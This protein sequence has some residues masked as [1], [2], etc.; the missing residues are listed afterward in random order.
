M[1]SDPAQFVSGEEFLQIL[2]RVL[3]LTEQDA[4]GQAKREQQALEAERQRTAEE[5][6][7]QLALRQVEDT[8]AAASAGGVTI[9]LSNITFQANSALLEEVERR[10]IRE[11]AEILTTMPGRKILVEGHTALAGTEA[12]Q[13]QTSTERAQA[14]ADY[15]VELGARRR[16]EITVRGY[17]ASRPV[18]DN[19]NAAGQAQNRRVEITILE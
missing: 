18:A 3:R 9:S 16:N 10:K 13:L 17:G 7:T 14:V 11:I 8:H 15:L 12:A 2:S 6:N 5:I 1:E 19:R 4:A